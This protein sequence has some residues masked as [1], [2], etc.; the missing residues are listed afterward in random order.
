M[1]TTT[2]S[3]RIDSD[4]KARAEK[5][6]D[7]IGISHSTAINALYSQIVLQNGMPFELRIPQ[8]GVRDAERADGVGG[9]AGEGREGATCVADLG[10]DSP[11]TAGDAVK[12]DIL[13][14]REI[15][16]CVCELADA[17]GIERA[18]LFGSYARGE[19]NGAS[20]VDIRVDKGDAHG[21]A[22]GGFQYDLAQALG[23]EVDVVSTDG[24]SPSLL[25]R[26][27]KDEV[28]LY[29]R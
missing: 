28:L 15:R 14:F 21:F 24:A 29:E 23:K 5:I 1:P 19:A 3:A 25:N 20:D 11:D 18:Y 4:L 7:A 22:L 12:K 26:I 13:S 2:V 16:N 6:M 9:V 27:S 10:I 8:K 17:Y